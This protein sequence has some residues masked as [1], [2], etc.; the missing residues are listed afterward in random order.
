MMLIGIFNY[1][2]RSE[3]DGVEDTLSFLAAHIA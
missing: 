3:G 1:A 2:A